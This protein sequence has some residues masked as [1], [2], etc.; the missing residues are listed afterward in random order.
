MVMTDITIKNIFPNDLLELVRQVKKKGYIQGVDFDFSYNP[1]KFDNFSG[2]S[3][4]E[5][6]AIFTFYKEELATWFS[7]TYL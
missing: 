7:L 6:T 5:R 3:V 2:E 1:P 4:Y